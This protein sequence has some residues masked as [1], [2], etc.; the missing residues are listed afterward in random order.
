MSLRKQLPESVTLLLP[1]LV[2]DAPIW[3]VGGGV[4]DHLLG[5]K[6]HDLD[7]AVDGDAIDIAKRIADE[8]EG[9]YYTLDEARGTGRVILEDDDGRRQTLDFDRIRSTCL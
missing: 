3:F 5:R 1:H 9:Y 7:F 2:Q 6:T 4:R 8:S